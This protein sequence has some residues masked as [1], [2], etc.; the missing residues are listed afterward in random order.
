MALHSSY[1]EEIKKSLNYV[2]TW[3]PTVILQPG[4]VCDMRDGELRRVGSLRD[5]DIAWQTQKSD[6]ES[7]MQYS[8]AGAVS[9]QLKA[10]GEAPPAGSLLNVQ[11]AGI[12]C[13]FSRS[14]AVVLQLTDCTGQS[15]GNL[16]KVGQEVLKRHDVHEWPEGHVVVS[17]VVR[18]GASTIIISSES[19]AGIDLAVKG[20]VGNG[21]LTLA[22]LN[23]GLNVKAQRKIG[24]QFVSA[25]G[26]TP[27]VRTKGIK[28]RLIRPDQFRSGSQVPPVPF[29]FGDVDYTS[30]D[31]GT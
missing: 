8:S 31:K 19:E 13:S 7:D 30:F 15:I 28:K 6:V 9:M 18:A 21:Q 24:A 12:T 25:P 23:A 4:D 2:A 11:D 22:S 16:I 3:L 1:L 27:L 17:E 20:A 14:G 26:L 10:Q 5:F 29:E